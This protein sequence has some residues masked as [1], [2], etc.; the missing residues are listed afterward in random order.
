MDYNQHYLPRQ[1]EYISKIK[2]QS[3]SFT[4]CW[5]A[6]SCTICTI[7]IMIIMIYNLGL[8]GYSIANGFIFGIINICLSCYLIYPMY[9]CGYT[10]T[11]W[12]L[13]ICWIISPFII[14]LQCYLSIMTRSVTFI[15]YIRS[16]NTNID[17]N[18]NS[19]LDTNYTSETQTARSK[20]LLFED[21][22]PTMQQT[23]KIQPMPTME[24]MPTMQ[25][26]PTMEPMPTITPS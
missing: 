11:S 25:P 4:S 21:S 5:P 2:N 1:Q 9:K 14:L 19:Q 6:L 13:F 10:A 12:I 26:M 15:S 7:C 18:T 20:E 3:I 17:Q 22:T 16:M 8:N 23:P 24:P